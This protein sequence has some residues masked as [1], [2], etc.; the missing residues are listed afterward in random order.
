MTTTYYRVQAG[1]RDPAQLLD[2]EQVSSY[3]GRSDL[4][5][6]G[7]SVCESVEDLAAYLAGPGQGIP[8]GLPGWVLVELEGEEIDGA[9]AVD[10]DGGEVLIRPTRVVSCQLIP[11]EL[12]EEIGRIFEENEAG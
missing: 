9:D 3:W 2:A 8:F 6:E 7:V 12:F 5:R 11:D 4:D 10:A 1:D